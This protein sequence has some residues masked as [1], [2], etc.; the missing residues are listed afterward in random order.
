MHAISYWEDHGSMIDVSLMEDEKPH[1]N[2]P[3][4][5]LSSGK[6][7]VNIQQQGGKWYA[8]MVLYTLRK[9]FVATV[10]HYSLNRIE[11]LH[12]GMKEDSPLFIFLLIDFPLISKI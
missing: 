8:I 12:Y 10:L 1:S 9:C 4:V 11:C 2:T 7:I 3:S 6:E 5:F